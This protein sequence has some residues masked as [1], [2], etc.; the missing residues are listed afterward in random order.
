MF[1]SVCLCVC[2]VSMCAHVGFVCVCMS[3][4]VCFVRTCVFLCACVYMY[5]FCVH[6]CA[7]AVMCVYVHV[8][9]CVLRGKRSQP[10]SGN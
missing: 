4:Q 8:W 9:L 7:Y 10:L 3:M 1:M 2:T 5:V 6:M